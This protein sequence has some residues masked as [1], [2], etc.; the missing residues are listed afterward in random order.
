MK[1]RLFKGIAL[2]LALC[3]TFVIGVNASNLL[4]PI[5]AFLNHGLTVEYNDVD[6]VMVDA[7]G[8]KV[9]PITYNGST[10]LP[11]RAI[12]NMVGIQVGWDEATQTVLL[13][14]SF[15]DVV[16]PVITPQVPETPLPTA[17]NSNV[18][19]VVNTD[20]V[21][22][23]FVFDI[24]NKIA[25]NKFVIDDFYLKNGDIVGTVLQGKAYDAG[26]TDIAYSF[27]G[28][29]FESID[30]EEVAELDA[31]ENEIGNVLIANGY[32]HVHTDEYGQKHYVNNQTEIKVWDISENN[33]TLSIEIETR[34]LSCHANHD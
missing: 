5:S 24:F 25:P 1:K 30:G 2:T 11:V 31:I 32:K 18:P 9:V 15:P 17:T 22:I 7:N 12:A 8:S 3:T 16:E 26:P 4:E 33:S 27:Y 23:G 10:Y 28:V 19:T 20:K 34:W 29:E 21:D 6:Q 13:G 14:N